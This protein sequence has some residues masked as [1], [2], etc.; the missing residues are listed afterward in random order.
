LSYASKGQLPGS[1]PV[2]PC[3]PFH[4]EPRFSMRDLDRRRRRQLLLRALDGIELGA[5]DET[6]LNWL[7][8][9]EYSTLLPIAGWIRR[10]R[11]VSSCRSALPRHNY[12]ANEEEEVSG[13]G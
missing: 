9:W 8:M 3:G 6:I 4:D 1:D 12:A 7:C 10:A 5:W 11:T 2:H 13:P